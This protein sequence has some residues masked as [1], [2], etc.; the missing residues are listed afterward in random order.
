M[1]IATAKNDRKVIGHYMQCLFLNLEV[2][3]RGVC[4]CVYTFRPLKSDAEVQHGHIKPDDN[5]PNAIFW[6]QC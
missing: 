5:L 2:D 6:V 3:Y 4:V 1:S